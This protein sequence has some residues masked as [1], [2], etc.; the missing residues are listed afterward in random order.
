MSVNNQ[1]LKDWEQTK[2]SDPRSTDELI[3]IA[4]SE[5]DINEAWNE[6]VVLHFRGNREVFEKAKNLCESNCPQER[7]LGAN[8]L[9]Q[10]GVP[11]ATGR[12][13][14]TRSR[15]RQTSGLK[16][17]DLQARTMYLCN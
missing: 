9:G 15:S 10:L 3:R 13:K 16:A 2:R 14:V 11:K 1:K 5:E 4:L 7:E 6:V 8:I 12:K 17:D